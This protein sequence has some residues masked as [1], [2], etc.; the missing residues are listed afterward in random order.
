MILKLEC[1][2]RVQSETKVEIPSYILEDPQGEYLRTNNFLIHEHES[3][4][5]K[6]VIERFE[7]WS[8]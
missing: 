7:Y 3:T 6:H 2:N 5:G 8:R 4:R 1:V